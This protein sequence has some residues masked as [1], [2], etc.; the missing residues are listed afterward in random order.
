MK[1]I[2]TVVGGALVASLLAATPV[3]ASAPVV[4]VP[5]WAAP[6]K[7]KTEQAPKPK[8]SI[9]SITK[10]PREIKAALEK[11]QN[12]IPE[13]KNLH[14]RRVNLYEADGYDPELWVIQ[15]SSNKNG[16]RYGSEAVNASLTFNAETGQLHEF[17]YENGKE[18]GE[19]ELT[20]EQAREKADAFLKKIFG[21]RKKDF[22]LTDVELWE[23]DEEED[24]DKA[25]TKRVHRAMVFYERHINGIP[26]QG[27]DVQV[28]VNAAGTVVEYRNS[29]YASPEKVRFPHPGKAL[30]PKK[31]EQSYKDLLNMS[32]VYDYDRVEDRPVLAYEP[33]FYGPI[34]AITGKKS[35]DLIYFETG[36]AQTIQVDGAGNRW[37]IRTPQDA[38]AML[39][40]VFNIPV[41]DLELDDEYEGEQFRWYSWEMDGDSELWGYVEIGVDKATGRLIDYEAE[42]E[43]EDE[44]DQTV[45]PEEAVASA[46]EVLEQFIPASK[47]QIQLTYLHNPFAKRDLPDWLKEDRN[48][49]DFSGQYSMVFRDL[50][51]GIPV[52]FSSYAVDIDPATG[53][54]LELSLR[55]VDILDG[56][57]E[58][59]DIVSA[60][61]AESALLAYRPLRLAY[62]WPRYED[63]K[64]AA[65]VLVY[66]PE[67]KPYAYIDAFTGRVVELEEQEDEE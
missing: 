28:V 6:S 31:A 12:Q 27:F 61:Q 41:E 16:S 4:E 25:E 44:P 34:D 57:P 42:F 20:E 62:I 53:M 32:L 46:A 63:R 23:D 26:L 10:L 5:M 38:E 47:K 43:R 40:Q 1:R 22:M 9:R 59:E 18:D 54:V 13:L 65:P 19:G 7:A 49:E 66:E 17:E 29:A 24:E 52:N 35:P 2:K 39:Q 64:A 50:Y 3:W 11:V 21:S 8:Q 37:V 30:S 45:N 14:V 33:A 67:S 56:L 58:A 15:L 48:E 55:D 60:D 36:D 51:D